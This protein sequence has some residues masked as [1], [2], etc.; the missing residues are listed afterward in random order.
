MQWFPVF[1]CTEASPQ[2]AAVMWEVFCKWQSAWV[3]ACWN[4]DGLGL[5]MSAAFCHE[6]SPWQEAG[7]RKLS[8]S[9]FASLWCSFEVNWL[10]LGRKLSRPEQ[11]GAVRRKTRWSQIYYHHL[12]W[13]VMPFFPWNQLQ[14]PQDPPLP[15]PPKVEVL[16][17][18]QALQ[19][20]PAQPVA[21]PPETQGASF[22]F[23]S[24]KSGG[25]L[26]KSWNIQGKVVPLQVTLHGKGIGIWWINIWV[27]KLCTTFMFCLIWLLKILAQREAS[28]WFWILFWMMPAWPDNPGSWG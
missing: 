22:G 4:W 24:D 11:L 8:N 5:S 15:P 1:K 19:L 17:T 16:Q 21:M 6:H 12:C 28:F 23:G 18:P 25:N 9:F 3:G 7:G 26:R 2:P 10:Q 13:I 14:D 27:D 20:E